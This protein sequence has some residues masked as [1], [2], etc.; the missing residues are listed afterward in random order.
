MQ[1]AAWAH[2]EELNDAYAGAVVPGGLHEEPQDNHE[3]L[4]APYAELGCGFS[5][6]ATGPL[7]P[8]RDFNRL[9][10]I[11]QRFQEGGNRAL[12]PQQGFQQAPRN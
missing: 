4:M 8:N 12:K 10:E 7:N 5:R 3:Y 11:Q 6:A 2:E 9:L 1:L